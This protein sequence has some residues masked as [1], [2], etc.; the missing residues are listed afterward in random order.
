MK[1]P[2]G[3][4]HDEG[5]RVQHVLLPLMWTSVEVSSVYASDASDRLNTLW[6]IYTE[7]GTYELIVSGCKPMFRCIYYTSMN[8]LGTMLFFI[9]EQL[10]NNVVL[11]PVIHIH[12]LIDLRFHY[13]GP[14]LPSSLGRQATWF[15]TLDWLRNATASSPLT[16][17]KTGSTTTVIALRDSNSRFR[18]SDSICNQSSW[19]NSQSIESIQQASLMAK[20]VEPEHQ[21]NLE[22]DDRTRGGTSW[23]AR[24]NGTRLI[25]NASCSCPGCKLRT[26]GAEANLHSD[27]VVH[28]C[29]KQ[30][31]ALKAGSNL[32]GQECSP[33]NMITHLPDDLL[34]NCLASVSR[35]HYPILSLVSKR[36]RSLIASLE[37]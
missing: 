11:Y 6:T 18:V 14:L 37:L 27:L 2:V 21:E 9:H 23:N 36:L 17:A 15:G 7:H 25:G 26:D 34:L 12:D 8:N 1:N 31:H 33:V 19:L 30:S 10:R 28:F 32:N 13:P 29:R 3:Q 20:I 22:L 4:K 35:L 16:M 24:W 5:K